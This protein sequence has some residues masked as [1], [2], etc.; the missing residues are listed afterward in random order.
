M[1]RQTTPPL[2]GPQAGSA[3]PTPQSERLKSALDTLVGRRDCQRLLDSAG[4]TGV[5]KWPASHLASACGVPLA[6][7]DKVVAARELRSDDLRLSSACVRAPIDVLSHLP[8]GFATWETEF[9]LAIALSAACRVL[10]V[11]LVAQGGSSSAALE[12]R[13]VFTPLVRF[14]ATAFVLVHN[15]PSGDPT[16]SEADVRL[17]DRIAAA[18]RVLA[19]E[20]LDHVIVSSSGATSLFETGL[21]PTETG[22]V[23]N[24]ENKHQRSA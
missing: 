17:T 11:V 24:E 19:I 23:L 10:A 9:V 3:L 15:H 6:C 1:F 18:G 16:P 13:D 14:R 21:L 20:M 7:A 8:R 12:P 5:L 22:M 2:P 4:L